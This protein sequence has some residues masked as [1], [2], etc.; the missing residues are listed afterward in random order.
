V[1]PFIQVLRFPGR[2]ERLESSTADPEESGKEFEQ[3]QASGLDADDQ[4]LK[5]DD[6]GVAEDQHKRRAGSCSGSRRQADDRSRQAAVSERESAH[7]DK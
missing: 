3:H 7:P 5:R 6:H 4:A 2:R 1:S